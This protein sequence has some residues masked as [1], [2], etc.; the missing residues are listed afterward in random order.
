MT[1]FS[2]IRDTSGYNSFALEFS[3]QNYSA[4]LSVGVAQ[5]LTIPGNASKYVCVFTI[6]SGAD[7]WVANNATAAYPAG[8]MAASNSVMNPAARFVKAG[9]VLSFIAQN[10]NA[11]I[12]IVLYAL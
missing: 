12:S 6:E 3:Q 1:Q 5:S 8:T 10:T 11:S 2:M 7:V 4:I 9:D